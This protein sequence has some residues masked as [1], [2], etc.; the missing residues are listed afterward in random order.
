VRCVS[1]SDS[2]GHRRCLS[3]RAA[4]FSSS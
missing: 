1:F 4:P 2:P 3:T